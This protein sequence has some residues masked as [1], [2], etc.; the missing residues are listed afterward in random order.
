[1]LVKYL[2][3]NFSERGLT[4]KIVIGEAG[5][6]GH[7]ATK[8]DTLGLRSDGRDEQARFFFSQESPFYIGDLPNVE[9]T[10]SAHSY[11]SVW[12]LDKQVEY[13][14]IVDDLLK[15]STLT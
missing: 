5:T 15:K 2:S 1:V 9:K 6:I 13:R 8:M 7:A 14:V 3:T 4:T 12:P 10:I 11:Y